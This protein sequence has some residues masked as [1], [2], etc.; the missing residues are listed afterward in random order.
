MAGR[1]R[2]CRPS[3]RP[4]QSDSTRTRIHSDSD[5]MW[6][7]NHCGHPDTVLRRSPYRSRN[8]CRNRPSRLSDSDD[9]VN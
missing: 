4:R 6:R 7:G 9:L 2:G 1:S 8:S 5:P 3:T